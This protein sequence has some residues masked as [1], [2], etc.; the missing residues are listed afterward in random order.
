MLSLLVLSVATM[1]Y[2]FFYQPLLLILKG[3]QNEAGKL[4][5]K[6]IGIFAAFTVAAFVVMF[7]LTNK[8]QQVVPLETSEAP[9]LEE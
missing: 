3:E 4:F 5:L 2:I 6:T 1:S 8:S 9:V 7:L